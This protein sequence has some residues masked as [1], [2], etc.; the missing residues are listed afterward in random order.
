MLPRC[1]IALAALGTGMHANPIVR[2]D[3][4]LG[5]V[6]ASLSS[7]GPLGDLHEVA[8]HGAQHAKTHPTSERLF[9]REDRQSPEASRVAGV[10]DAGGLHPVPRDAREQGLDEAESAGGTLE[11]PLRAG[12]KDEKGEQLLEG[13]NQNKWGS[14]RRQAAVPIII[15]IPITPVPTPKPTAEPTPSPTPEPTP[16]P[17]ASPTPAPTPQ[18]TPRPTAR[19]T[20]APTTTTTTTEETTTMKLTAL[21]KSMAASLQ[22]RLPRALGVLALFSVLWSLSG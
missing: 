1:C 3:P 13:D 8:K 2:S 21:F 7:Y 6:A 14:R 20:P 16:S 17:T 11:A 19:P 22:A 15:R 12:S 4:P 5:D 9:R 10:H 18:P